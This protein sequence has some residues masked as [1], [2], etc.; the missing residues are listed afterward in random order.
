ML[1]AM[2]TEDL[3]MIL[4]GLALALIGVLRLTGLLTLESI[5]FIVFAVAALYISFVAGF[6]YGQPRRS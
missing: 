2:T 6:Q 4:A 3:G 5:L 1:N